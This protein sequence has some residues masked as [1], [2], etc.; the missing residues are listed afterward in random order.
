VLLDLFLE[1]ATENN[2]LNHRRTHLHR[3]H[4]LSSAAIFTLVILVL[5]VGCTSTPATVTNTVTST[6]PPVTVTVTAT[7]AA[8]TAQLNQLKQ[9]AGPPPASLDQYFP[10]ASPAPVFLLQ[11]FAMATPFEG[12][13]VSLQENDMTNVKANF[14]AFQ[15]EYGKAS[16]MV[17]EWT[18]MFPQDA[19]TAM[20][21]AITAGDPAKIGAAMGGLGAV[22]TNCH[23]LYQIKVEQKYHWKDFATI[24]VTNPVTKQSQA[25]VD[26]MTTMAGGFDGAA[27]DLQEGKTANAAKNFNDFVTEY[28]ALAT[29]GCK[30]CHTDPM[31]GKEIPRAYFVDPASMA[32]IDQLNK[33]FAATPPDTTTITN[34]SGAIGNNICLSCHLIHVPAQNAKDTWTTYSNILK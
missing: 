21:T 8:N 24:K 18:A 31:T 30:Q 20:G 34:L 28:K 23:L 7:P 29:D 15:T 4:L 10:P 2:I 11:M 22:C 13:G 19:V 12:I 1:K 5:A 17:P 27:I 33:A 25:W 14:A 32:M 16:K 9:I 26:Y 3:F 6:P